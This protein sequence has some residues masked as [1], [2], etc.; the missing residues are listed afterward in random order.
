MV[1]YAYMD[2]LLGVAESSGFNILDQIIQL[3]D[4]PLLA[5]GWLLTH[6]AWVVVIWV[7]LW[8]ARE[9]WSDWRQ[10][11]FASK[12]TF[13][14]LA[15]DVPRATEQT[16]K[17]VENMFAHLAGAHSDPTFLEKWIDG[18]HQMPI[19]CEIISIE[20]HVQF[21]LRI[22]DKVRDLVEAS[23]YAQY[24][25]AEI[26][27]VE[28]YVNR[29]PHSFPD[30]HYDCFAFEFT[31]AKPGRDVYPLKTYM[32][33]E[34]SMTKEFKD[35]LAALLEML[36]RLGP[37]EQMW[38]QI[39]AKPIAQGDFTS[40]VTKEV[41]KITGQKEA[42]KKT[43]I[44]KALDAPIS[45]LGAT[46]D[47]LFGGAEAPV[48][49]K[50]ENLLNSRMWNL[51][52]G[53]RK[54]VEGLERKMSKIAYAVKI[55]VIYIA[56]KEVFSKARVAY[57]VVGAMKQYNAND[58]LSLKPE[59]KRVGVSSSI[60]LFGKHRNNIR[61]GKLVR[62]Y[63]GRSSW[64]GLP[65]FFLNTE[66]LASLWHLPVSLFVKA[67]QVKKTESKKTEPPINLPFG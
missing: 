39:L 12:Q 5:M 52:P 33:F 32:D 47:I 60:V 64:V 57:S 44:D 34:D 50:E 35:P 16:V 11:I 28:D 59:G 4:N 41:K 25:D 40:A 53:E 49:K 2:D 66:E 67:P 29:V 58:A 9:L 36:A 45:V 62:A 19:S 17:A 10:G 15:V 6:G 24:P 46:G 54:L 31:P 27:E 1:S 13:I 43:M 38:Y 48:K 37:G 56:K 65:E 21:L 63:A 61:K 20:G 3:G 7:I 26:T 22:V 18:K 23:L 51:T 42:P 30:E 8:G 14:L 55:R